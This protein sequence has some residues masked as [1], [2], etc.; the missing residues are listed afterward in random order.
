ME[1]VQSVYCNQHGQQDL[2]LICSHLLAGRNEPIGFYEC[3]PED[4]AWCNECEKAL[5][6]TR[7]DDEQDQWSQ[8]CDYKIVCAVCWGSIKESNQIIKNPMNLTELEQKYTIQYPEVYRQ[9]AENNMLDWGVSGSNWYHDTFPKLKANP[10]LL[11]FGYDI[12]IWNDQE[13]VE[14]SID[15]MS[16]EEDYRNIHP[17]YQFIP[18][19]QNGA[20]DLYAFQFDLQNNGEVPVVFIPHDDEEAEIL[21]GN[22]QD[23]IFRQLLESVTEIDEDSMFYEEEEENLKQNLFNQLKTH[24]PYLTAKQIEILNTIYQ[25][26]L[27][28]YTYKVPNGSSFETEGLVTFDE[29]EE[30]INQQ[31]SFEHL[32]RRFN[33]TESPKP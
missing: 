10:P 15:E 8:D 17:D 5:S 29:V 24:E 32:N 13:L 21:A 33:Y 6:K 25:R 27:F 14:T 3:E 31:L 7:T 9:L 12:E 20:G 1:E 2:K 16:D 22:F 18:F 26:D 28:E 19:A 23:F 11:L 30:I 4:M